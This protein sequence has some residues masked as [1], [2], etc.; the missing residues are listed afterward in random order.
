MLAKLSASPHRLCTQSQPHR[1]A[2]FHDRY[3]AR[4]AA[5]SR[6]KGQRGAIAAVLK[7]LFLEKENP[8]GPRAVRV[9]SQSI[10]GFRG[11][12]GS[13]NGFPL[14]GDETARNRKT[15]RFALPRLAK[16]PHSQICHPKPC[17]I[18]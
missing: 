16:E 2:H 15:V 12:R 9:S 1:L 3:K 10:V 18:G 6:K 11:E 4:I 17:L 8:Q 13:Y 7:R 14:A 5:F